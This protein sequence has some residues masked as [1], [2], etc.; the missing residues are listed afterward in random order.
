M[1]AEGLL[2]AMSGGVP[3]R[4][5][6]W[7]LLLGLFS[8]CVDLTTHQKLWSAAVGGWLSLA[9]GRL[10]IAGMNGDLSAYDLGP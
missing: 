6:L 10:F 2:M 7:M 4:R 9:E 5:A 1:R 3:A 8:G